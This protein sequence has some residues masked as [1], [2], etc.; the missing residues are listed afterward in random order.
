MTRDR[1][2]DAAWEVFGRQGFDGATVTEIE[3]RAGLAGGSGGFYRHFTSKEDVLHAVVEREIARA[4]AGRE[5]PPDELAV[6]ARVALSQEFRRRLTNLRRLQPLIALLAREERHLTDA[7][8][9]L[10]DLLIRKNVG[11]RADIL[12]GW[13]DQGAIPRRDPQAL[14]TVIT[15][16]LSGYQAALQFFGA[17]PWADEESVVAMLADLVLGPSTM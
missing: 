16:A 6:D 13:M 17:S 5:L 8:Q 10:R 2:L 3:D 7:K 4:D 12:R 1:I 15:A 9:T 14:A 11:L